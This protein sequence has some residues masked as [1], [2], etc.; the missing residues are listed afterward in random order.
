ME[1]VT[2]RTA[3]WFAQ[4]TSVLTRDGIP[5]EM[6]TKVVQLAPNKTM[7]DRAVANCEIESFSKP[8]RGHTTDYHV[9]PRWYEGD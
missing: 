4:N 1:L 8:P 2:T 5:R 7:Y 9:D 6:I 3:L